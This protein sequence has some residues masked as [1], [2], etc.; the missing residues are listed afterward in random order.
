MKSMLTSVSLVLSTFLLLGTLVA[1]GGDERD[2]RDDSR[3][4]SAGDR[5]GREGGASAAADVPGEPAGLIPVGSDFAILFDVPEMLSDDVPGYGR[6]DFVD[7][8]EELL[9]G[10]IDLA[11]A[12]TLLVIGDSLLLAQGRFDFSQVREDLEDLGYEEDE[13]QGFEVWGERAAL[14]EQE[15]YVILGFASGAI[16]ELLS[17]LDRGR[18]LLAFEHNS[19]L[20]QVVDEVGSGTVVLLASDCAESD[21]SGCDAAGVSLLPGSQPDLTLIRGFFLFEDEESAED[22]LAE[23]EDS[24]LDDSDIVEVLD[25]GTD[26]NAVIFEFEVKD[27]D[28][29]SFYDLVEDGP[30]ARRLPPGS[31]SPAAEADPEE[32]RYGDSGSRTSLIPAS[33]RAGDS[34]RDVGRINPGQIAN[35][36]IGRGD[37]HY[38]EFDARRGLTYIIETDAGFDSYLELLDDSGD[39]I[40]SDDDGGS[41]N[42]SLITWTARYSGGHVI[43]VRGYSGSQTGSYDLTLT[44]LEADDHAASFNDATPIGDGDVANGSI[45][46]GDEDYFVFEARRGSAYIMETS[47]G[48]DTVIELYDDEGTEIAYDDDDGEDSAS[49]LLWTAEYSGEYFL[50]VRGY[51]GNDT[52]SYRLS[53]THIDPDD[54]G[55]NLRNATRLNSDDEADGTILDGD[56]DFFTFGARRGRTYTLETVASF[57]T[58]IELY[59]DEGTEIAYDDDGGED[60]ASRLVW[61]A[62]YSGEHFVVVRGYDYDDIGVYRFLI[63]ESR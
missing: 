47:A 55:N 51:D 52:G 39:R 33:A 24:L 2:T 7:W 18:N 45:V 41:G 59:D 20:A 42:S 23:A 37:S 46:E 12:D 57:D 9:D 49:R 21:V 44:A 4:R 6:D 60:S 30:V 28:F 22:A 5:S 48:F 32:T 16:R 56:E 13:Y 29:G 62:E 14:I 1:C 8:A 53:L 15:D 63:S 61:E 17:A 27:D 19:D 11:D 54:H 3:E 40:E 25:F 38:Y 34:I 31:P 10:D 35:D 50:K 26:G 58:V 36:R 43:V